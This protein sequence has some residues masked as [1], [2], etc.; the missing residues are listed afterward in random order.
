MNSIPSMT[1]IPADLLEACKRGDLIVCVGPELGCSAGLPSLAELSVT[2]LEDGEIEGRNLDATTI[3]EWI[4]VGR[5]EEA[6]EALEGRMGTRFQ[7]VVE[8]ELGE[9][10]RP[11]PA[12]ARAI[13]ALEGQLRAVYTTGVDRLLERAFADAWPSFSTAQGDLTRRRKVIVKLCGTLEF[14]ETL[15]LT[16]AALDREFG[17]RSLRRQL[18]DAAYRAHCLL[19]VGFE[20]MDALGDRLFSVFDSALSDGQPPSH[21]VILRRCALEDRARLERR[22]L[23]VLVGD[24]IELLG[25]LGGEHSRRDADTSELPTHPY[26]G[27]QAFDQSMVA[28]FHGRR[29][30][31]SAAASRLG[32][33]KHRHRR[34][35]AIDG[36]SGV[37]KSSFVHAGLIPALGR[38]FAEGTPTRWRIASLRP[39]RQPLHALVE[40]LAT[41]LGVSDPS[42]SVDAF[43]REHTPAN[44]ALLVVVDQFEEVVTLAEPAERSSFAACLT[45]LL[46]HRLIYLVTTLRSDFSAV[47]SASMPAFARL[48]NEHAERYTLAPIS[49]VGLRA[50][51][52]EPA[53]QVG[54]RFEPELVER[55]AS[56]AEQ[57]LGQGRTDEDGVVRTDDA[58]LPLVAHVL[59][60]LWDARAA[61]DGEICFAEYEALGGVSGAL[62]RSADTLLARLDGQQ[63]SRVKTLLL[64][65]VDL[66]DGRL[67]RRTLS[68]LEALS[69]AGGGEA[70]EALLHLLSGG[71]GPRLI[72]IRSE[73]SEALVDLV[74]EALLREW[75]TM[76]GWIAADRAQLAR[77]EALARRAAAWIDQGRPWRSLPRGRE[78]RELQR[79]RAHGKGALEQRDYQRAMRSAVWSRAGAWAGLIAG[80]SGVGYWG[81]EEMRAAQAER[82]RQVEILDGVVEDRDV[83]ETELEAEKEKGEKEEA[84]DQI[85]ELLRS[86]NCRKALQRTLSE[87]PEDHELSREVVSCKAIVGK[88]ATLPGPEAVTSVAIDDVN[89]AAW[90]GRENGAVQ[91]WGLDDHEVEPITT[92]TSSIVTIRVA[93]GGDRVAVRWDGQIRV[94]DEHGEMIGD[95]YN[96]IEPMFSPS[97][98]ILASRKGTR[99]EVR[100]AVDA[101]FQWE[102]D[103]ESTIT[104]FEFSDRGDRLILAG[105]KRAGS[106]ISSLDTATGD[107][108]GSPIHVSNYLRD[109]AVSPDGQYVAST[110]DDKQ[111]RL[112]SLNSGEPVATPLW[113]DMQEPTRRFVS[114]SPR[115]TVVAA[116]NENERVVIAGLD[117]VRLSELGDV[118]P[119]VRPRFSPGEEWLLTAS[120]DEHAM[121]HE[122][123]G[124][125]EVAR[126]DL[127]DKAA[128]LI[129]APNKPGRGNILTRTERGELSHW[130]VDTQDHWRAPH[131]HLQAVRSIAFSPTDSR[132]LLSGSSAGTIDVWTIGAESQ[133]PAV[134]LEGWIL[135]LGSSTRGDLDVAYSSNGAL[136]SWTGSEEPVQRASLCA[137]KTVAL[138]SSREHLAVACDDGS[139]VELW[140]LVQLQRTG[141]VSTR[142]D[143]ESLALSPAG[144]KLALGGSSGG[145]EVVAIGGDATAGRE[146]LA[147]D[148]M[149][150]VTGLSF[151]QRGEL[152]VSGGNDDVAKI[153]SLGK[154]QAEPVELSMLG[155]NVESVAISSTAKRV[156][157]GDEKGTVMVWNLDGTEPH[158]FDRGCVGHRVHALAFSPDDQLLAA[159]CSDG[160]VH[161]WPLGTLALLELGRERLANTKD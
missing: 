37:G 24:P 100:A 77:D 140:D 50:A 135:A 80:L 62:S 150:A 1:S 98:R 155:N 60:G 61:E 67:T 94:L 38:G 87:F 59:R 49:R 44:E 4:A 73:G 30:E 138:G 14:P 136:L 71:G 97:G 99:V 124:D 29:A 133:P 58:A 3:R 107:L 76:C 92:L 63:R 116:S 126:L 121:V 139:G 85:A 102:F 105:A 74:H 32:G 149:A 18:L 110:A 104:A 75:D 95:P 89:N 20:P 52:T 66:D 28:V 93:Q 148:S 108:I 101:E 56:D 17:E 141:T 68:R 40:A 96:G 41:A 2:L 55:I 70:G 27:L 134:S 8:R 19:F 72:V 147:T 88:I 48:L 118:D 39:G 142:L 106:T 78:R 113:L 15:A 46:E 122:V 109:I 23:R 54:V 81:I 79:G 114:F 83:I 137:S 57:H 86:G 11:P 9:I 10:G 132:R 90:I 16:R 156:A 12:L 103:A 160:S 35:L 112:W 26:P 42:S 33:P 34:W 69:L 157:A 153:W 7:R 5:V 130:I 64:R 47:L 146:T 53:T 143:V 131:P 51:I 21:F 127:G 91:R 125:D 84:K 115:G 151:D 25:E 128:E 117:L 65:M 43:V 22:G 119:A 82:D 144:D 45:L 120:F 152:L 158:R 111:V 159:G 123:N 129:F 161:A 31:I 6:L 13:A 36:S 154:R 145:I